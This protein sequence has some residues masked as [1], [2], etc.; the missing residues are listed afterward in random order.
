MPLGWKSTH[1]IR[2]CRMN[3]GSMISAHSDS[4][5]VH[6]LSIDDLTNVALI[7]LRAFPD[8]A[9]TKLGKE[10][11]RRYYEWQMIG[12][13]DASNIGAFVES[14]LAGFCF[15]GVFRGALGG[16][17]EKNRNYLIRQVI[18]HPWLLLNPLFRERASLAA[19]RI[20][21]KLF[22]SKV[23]PASPRI[24][25]SEKPVAFGILSIAVDPKFQGSG[26]AQLLMEHAENIALER[27][28]T[29]MRLSVH[30]SNGRAV[31]FYEKMGWQRVLDDG[32]WKGN[33]EKTLTS[34]SVANPL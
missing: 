15:G 32:I 21:G 5:E 8:S 34:E 11:V 4:I 29:L 7:H 1:M 3:G 30:P 17:L 25:S 22:R 28:F 6:P 24:V 9:L 12:P 10:P 2:N 31:R 26:V 23:H 14:E 18:T 20:S 13:H 16:F 33:M 19:K 27:G